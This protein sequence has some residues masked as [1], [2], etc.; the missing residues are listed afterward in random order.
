MTKL[1]ASA[2]LIA[3]TLPPAQ[4]TATKQRRPEIQEVQ[5]RV[6][7]ERVVVTGRVIDRFANPIPGL[8][9]GDFRLRVEGREA[10]IESIE[11]IPGEPRPPRSAVETT[12]SQALEAGLPPKVSTAGQQTPAAPSRTI[13]MLFQWEI[14]GQK[15][16]GFVRMMRQ[17][18]RFVNSA[19]PTDR[20][21]VLGFGS[22]L[23]L[24]QDLTTDHGAVRDAI[25]AVRSLTFS[26]SAV[27]PDGPALSASITGCGSTGSIQ[28]AI[29]CIGNSLQSFPGSKTMLFFGWSIGRGRGPE[30]VEYPKMIEAIGKA[31]TSVWVLDVSGGKHTLAEGIA[32]LAFETGGLYNGG[33]IYETVYCADLI[34]LKVHRAVEGGTYEIVFRNPAAGR[35][36]HEVD[37]ELINRS[38]T[39]LFQRW[40]RN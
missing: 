20:F 34:R 22:S 29:I 24:L 39:P 16:T 19:N 6:T 23:K 14:A 40:Y 32:R 2:L 35:G 25:E 5:E 13:V 28:K 7:V 27:T 15:D 12:T 9:I 30:R 11:W 10:P 4:E 33:C 8:G 26:G 18:E 21:A 3:L 17:A 37:I 38:G 31:Q 36:W 1:P